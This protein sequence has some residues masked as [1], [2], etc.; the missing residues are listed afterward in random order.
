MT[1]FPVLSSAEER[2]SP[3]Y[4]LKFQI[5][6]LK[7]LCTSFLQEDCDIAIGMSSFEDDLQELCEY[8]IEYIC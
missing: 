5:Q 4:W 2:R 7:F 8:F 1:C 6:I 3:I